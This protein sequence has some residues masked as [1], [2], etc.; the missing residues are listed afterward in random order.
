[1]ADKVKRM[2]RKI[3]NTEEKRLLLECLSK[4]GPDLIKEMDKLD[5]GELESEIV[6][7]MRSAITDEFVQNGLKKDDE[8]N[9]YGLELED[10]IDKLADLYIWPKELKK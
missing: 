2:T 9:E 10:L 5:T 7:E 6:N 8:P 3:L 4:H 1:M